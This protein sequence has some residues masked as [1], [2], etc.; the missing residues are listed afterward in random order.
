M[1]EDDN[2]ATDGRNV[3]LGHTAAIAGTYR[4]R[5]RAGIDGAGRRTPRKVTGAWYRPP[6]VGDKGLEPPASTV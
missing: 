2:G 6:A 1:A 4:L 3:L 5:V